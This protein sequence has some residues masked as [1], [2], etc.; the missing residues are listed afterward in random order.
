MKES[1][2][3]PYETSKKLTWR[4]YREL[5]PRTQPNLDEKFNPNIEKTINGDEVTVHPKQDVAGPYEW[6][7]FD[8]LHMTVGMMT[9]VG[10]LFDCCYQPKPQF[11]DIVNFKEEL[12]DYSWYL[13][14]YCNIHNININFGSISNPTNIKDLNDLL[15][16][17]LSFTAQLLD[18]DKRHFAYS[19]YKEGD[20]E[21]ICNKIAS[22]LKGLLSSLYHNDLG[23][24]LQQIWYTNIKKL[25]ERYPDAF[26][27]EKAVD[28]DLG[29]ER[30][31]LE[32]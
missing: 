32:G 20:R 9:E 7:K 5:Q 29:A 11:I 6:T 12:G 24:T 27:E 26:S 2:L 14:A 3:L 16:K 23:E 17:L 31:I 15:Y 13:S 18:F 22:V 10:E 19:K 8:S 30:Q 28:R 1:L 21:L 4:Q 25:E